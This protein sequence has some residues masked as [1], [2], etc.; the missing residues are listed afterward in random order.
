MATWMIHTSEEVFQDLE[1][2]RP[3]GF[4][5][6]LRNHR[7]ENMESVKFHSTDAMS[8]RKIIARGHRS[9]KDTKTT[10]QVYP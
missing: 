9:P 10:P 4:V 6:P 2:P 5:L 7:G 3:T 1:I 8:S